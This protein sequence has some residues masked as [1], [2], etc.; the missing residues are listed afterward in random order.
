MEALSYALRVAT[1]SPNELNAT[2]FVLELERGN[3]MSKRK[4]GPRDLLE[5]LDHE[6][7]GRYDDG[8]GGGGGSQGFDASDLLYP[9]TARWV[10]CA[11][12]N[13]TRPGREGDDNAARSLMNAGI[14]D[15]ILRIVNVGTENDPASW[16]ANSPQDAALFTL[17]NVAGSGSH[18]ARQYL[19]ERNAAKKFYL[20][21][22]RAEAVLGGGPAINGDDKILEFQRLKAV[23]CISV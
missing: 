23:S 6:D 15:Y 5:G 18:A 9:E 21:T 20:V 16:D 4:D 22:E 10:L 3:H 12:K 11:L 1:M 13:L 14:L 2:E 7:T 19:I 17:L 8:R